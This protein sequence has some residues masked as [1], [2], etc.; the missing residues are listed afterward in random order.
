MNSGRMET[1]ENRVLVL[2]KVYSDEYSF[3]ITSILFLINNCKTN[4]YD[5]I[6]WIGFKSSFVGLRCA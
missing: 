5:N 3:S 1:G 2:M 4:V 6:V